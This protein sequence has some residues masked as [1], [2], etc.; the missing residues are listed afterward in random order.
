MNKTDTRGKLYLW[1]WRTSNRNG[2]YWGA[3]S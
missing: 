2:K 1:E 3:V